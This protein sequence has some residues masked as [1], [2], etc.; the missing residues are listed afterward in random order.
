ML[1]SV[2]KPR[3]KPKQIGE[4]DNKNKNNTNVLCGRIHLM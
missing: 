1:A 4:T 2:T 3:D